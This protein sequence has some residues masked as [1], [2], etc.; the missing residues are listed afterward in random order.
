MLAC[1]IGVTPLLSLLWDLPYRA[2]EATLVYRVRSAAGLAFGAELKQLAARRGVRLVA[3]VGPRATP[4]SWLPAGHP[5]DEV[6]ALHATAPD[7]ANHQV[8]ICGPD[9]WTDAARTATLAAGVPA[10]RIHTERFAW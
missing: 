6:E 4:A 7:I 8:Y 9:G 3:L 2:G 1:G 5:L 10:G